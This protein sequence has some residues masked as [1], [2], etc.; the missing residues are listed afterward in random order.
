MIV[1]GVTGG[2]G[3][4]KTQISNMLAKK[5]GFAVDADA[6][7]H[8]MLNTCAEMISEITEAFPEVNDGKGGVVRKKLSEIVFS[9]NSKL[10][11]LN[12]ITHK[13]IRNRLDEIV[14][15]CKNENVEMLIIDAPTLFESGADKLCDF[16]VGVVAPEEERVKRIQNRDGIDKKR[17]IAR[18]KS[19]P[20]DDFYYDKCDCTVDSGESTAVALADEIYQIIMKGMTTGNE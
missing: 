5:G 10:L 3:S 20:K 2:S 1:V 11:L 6:L 14:L 12:K 8:G 7:Y 17:A 19:Q 9:D 18:I 16:T 13:Y 15:Q 4:G